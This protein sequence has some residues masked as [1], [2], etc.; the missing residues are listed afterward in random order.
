[1]LALLLALACGRIPSPCRTHG[2]DWRRGSESNKN[3]GFFQSALFADYRPTTK[4]AL[5][6]NRRTPV[7]SRT[8]LFVSSTS[9]YRPKN[10]EL[11]TNYSF[12]TSSLALSL[13]LKLSG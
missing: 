11:L 7:E 12:T 13:A 5:P 8:F 6:H 1:L 3:S 2:L 9:H 4:G 10:R